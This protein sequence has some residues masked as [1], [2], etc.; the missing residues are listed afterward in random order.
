MNNQGRF[1]VYYHLNLS[2]KNNSGLQGSLPER[3]DQIVYDGQGDVLNNNMQFHLDTKHY[4]VE[5]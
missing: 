1:T 4:D 3:H 2:L 5:C